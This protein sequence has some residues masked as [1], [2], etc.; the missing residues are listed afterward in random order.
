MEISHETRLAPPGGAVL[1]NGCGLGAAAGNSTSPPDRNHHNRSNYFP[2]RHK[3]E[4]SLYDEVMGTFDKCF[5]YLKPKD[6]IWSLP[7]EDNGRGLFSEYYQFDSLQE[8]KIKLNEVK[9]QL[10][11]YPIIE[12]SAHTRRKNPA[13][14]IPWRLKTDIK[15]E[16]VTIA[17][18]K[19]FE[20]L[21]KCPE[22]V[23]GPQ[24][25]SL[26]LCEAPGAF[27]TALNHYLFTRYSEN[28]VSDIM[29]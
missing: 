1:R 2:R 14:E 28:E 25:N 10:N 8:L 18:C 24:L 7:S 15:A 19:L 26:H 29:K 16:F 17:W 11:D 20:C 23:K 13:G 12:W 22:M 9:S 5:V 3:P 27:I 21:N 6:G 4:T